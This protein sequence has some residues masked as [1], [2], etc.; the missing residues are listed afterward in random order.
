ML[1][2][3]L[4]CKL[5]NFKYKQKPN[6]LLNKTNGCHFC[7]KES[8]YNTENNKLKFINKSKELFPSLFLYDK[9]N[10]I[11]QNKKITLTCINHGDFECYPNNHLNGVTSCIGCRKNTETKFKEIKTWTKD[12]YIDMCSKNHKG[13]S[14]I[15]LI[16]LS[17]EQEEFYKVG[18]T[19]K[20][21]IRGRYPCT[22]DSKYKIEEILFIKEKSEVVFETEKLFLKEFKRNKYKPL[23][24]FDGFSECIKGDVNMFVDYIKRKING[25]SYET[26]KYHIKI[27]K[28]LK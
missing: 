5:H 19:V 21:S 27:A 25:S 18:I 10:Y 15:Y 9:C 11:N 16:K 14:N 2:V 20:K 22:F 3:I 28:E 13:F 17:N 1:P 23:K 12:T 6:V 4:R 8:K 24:P 26:N 7:V